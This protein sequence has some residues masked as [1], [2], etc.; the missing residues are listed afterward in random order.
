LTLF[1]A[2]ACDDDAVPTDPSPSSDAPTFTSE[3]LPGNEVPPVTGPDAAGRGSV[4]MTLNLTRDGAQNITAATA[5]FQ[6]SLTGFPANTTLTGAHIHPGRAGSNGGIIIN[7][8]IT[9]G[10]INLPAGATTFSRTGRNVTPEVAQNLLN[11]PAGFY[12]NVH[13]TLNTGGAV[14]GQ[15]IRTQ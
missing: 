13:T 9:S 5:D 14:R 3:L 6:V 7:T 10:E 4:T 8:G 15:M 2:A 1:A 11:D 12:F